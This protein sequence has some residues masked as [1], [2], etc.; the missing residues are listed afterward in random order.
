MYKDPV[1]KIKLISTP[2]SVDIAITGGCNLNCKYCFYANEMTALKD[3][4]FEEWKNL[5]AELKRLNVFRVTLTGGEPFTRSDLFKLIDEII[6]NR[7]RYNILTNG[8]LINEKLLNQFEKGK[9]R[10]RL[11]SIQ[12][13]IDGSTAEIHN[14]SRPDSFEKAV[15]GLRLL[16]QSGFP[17]VVR[18]TINKYNL[19]DLENIAQLLL[20]DIGLASFSTNE[21]MPVGLGCQNSQS[22]SLTPADQLI[23]MEY[24]SKLLKKYPERIKAQ[25]G[26]LAKM[27]MYSEMEMA[28]KTGEKTGR[29]RMGY[30][31]ACGC[32]FSRIDVQH[33]GT[34]VPCHMLPDLHL[35][36]IKD[37]SIA[38]I[39]QTHPALS[40]LRQRRQIPMQEVEGCTDCEW[41]SYCN[42]SCPGL[43]Y[44]LTGDFNRANP[45]DC[46]RRFLSHTGEKYAV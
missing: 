35:G 46:F 5:F 18:V 22:V 23:A 3:L 30:L 38:E 37:D 19:H 40:A 27:K 4:S 16:K 17:L 29:W 15:Q 32:V 21:A 8:T 20:E 31:T 36:N 33:D 9:R 1:K 39:W 25:A 12:V 13:S 14:Q 11:D 42:G 28:K 41:A 2:K 10:M 45:E 24:I 34:I 7:M 6:F 26:P 43:A 44:Q